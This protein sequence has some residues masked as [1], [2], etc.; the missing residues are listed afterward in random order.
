MRFATTK[1]APRRSRFR[2][3]VLNALA[4]VASVGTV[5]LATQAAHAAFPEKTIRVV[6]GAPPGGT[7]DLLA[8][9]LAEDLGKQ[10]GQTVIVDNKP[11]AAGM[12]GAQ[13][14]LKSPRDGH[15]LL[16]A[17]SALVSEIPHALKL[18]IDPAKEFRPLADLGRTGLLFVTAPGVTASS[19]KDA[20][21]W[22]KANPGKTSYASYS[23]GTVSHTLGVIFNR[24]FG[25]DMTHA[26]YRGSPPALA[27]LAGNHVQFMFDGPATSIP[28]IKGGKIRVLAT[29]APTRLSVL[30]EVPTFAELGAPE[31]TETAWIGLWVT[32]DVPAAVQTTLRDATLKA[33]AQPALRQKLLTLGFDMPPA[34]TPEELIRA[35]QIASDKQAAT[36]KAIGFKPE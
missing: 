34:S 20:V 8:R 12:L 24:Q 10:L 1:P 15:T 30:P 4:G 14:V 32:P 36:L 31:L 27:D 11:G 7:S 6:V 26:P 2:R 22:I 19:L 25:T 21:A 13:E 3:F 35:L 18:P 5:L 16:V 23:A 29:T 28:Q 33:W 9:L 17:P